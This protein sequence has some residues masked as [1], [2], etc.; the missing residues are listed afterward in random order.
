MT[1]KKSRQLMV[2]VPVTNMR[3]IAKT[4]IAKTHFKTDPDNDVQRFQVKIA[5]CVCLISNNVVAA[6]YDHLYIDC[7]KWRCHGAI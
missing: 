2:S 3:C 1:S 6:T 4:L 7:K 5:L